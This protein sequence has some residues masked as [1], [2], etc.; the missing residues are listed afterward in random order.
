[1]GLQRI[2][3][4]FHFLNFSNAISHWE[5]CSHY[6]HTWWSGGLQQMLLFF[7]LTLFSSEKLQSLSFNENAWYPNGKAVFKISCIS[8]IASLQ[9]LNKVDWRLWI[10]CCNEPIILSRTPVIFFYIHLSF[11]WQSE[12]LLFH[13]WCISSLSKELSSNIFF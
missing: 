3:H 13:H 4:H 5:Y 8:W 10:T 2:G 7:M 9:T 6:R 11:C 12:S 1:M